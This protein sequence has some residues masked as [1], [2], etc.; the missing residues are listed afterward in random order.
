MTASEYLSSQPLVT[1]RIFAVLL[2]IAVCMSAWWGF[3]LPIGRLFTSQ[4]LWRTTAIREL[5]YN[6]GVVATESDA[7]NQLQV[8]RTPSTW[9]RFFQ[10]GSLGPNEQL[11]AEI[12][13]AL[14]A[15]GAGSVRLT[16]LP[17]QS[18]GV[19]RKY[20]L[21]VVATVDAGQLKRFLDALRARSHYLRV[22]QLA[23]NAPLRQAANENPPLQLKADI[24]GYANTPAS[25]AAR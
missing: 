7:R 20:G 14:N 22:E 12:E 10:D 21:R 13:Q 16:S 23:L 4:D 18:D 9:Q 25:R 17:A 11:K 24:F 3:M 6:R 1:R 2:L 8:L 19:L 5:G 15:S